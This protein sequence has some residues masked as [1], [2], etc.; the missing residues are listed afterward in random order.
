MISEEQEIK[1]RKLIDSLIDLTI[2]VH[3]NSCEEKY[4]RESI[5]DLIGTQKDLDDHINSLR[6]GANGSLSRREWIMILYVVKNQD[7][8]YFRAKGYGGYGKHG[9]MN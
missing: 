4:L 7:G 9:L 3:D 1:L 6:I 5:K 2:T 8:Q